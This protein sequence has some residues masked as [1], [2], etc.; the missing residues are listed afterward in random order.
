MIEAPDWIVLQSRS[1]MDENNLRLEA[2]AVNK[3]MLHQRFIHTFDEMNKESIMVSRSKVHRSLY[4]S[5]LHTEIERSGC[6]RVWQAWLNYHFGAR[7]S[8]RTVRSGHKSNVA[9]FLRGPSL[10]R[11]LLLP[12][13]FFLFILYCSSD[14]HQSST[15]DRTT[16]IEPILSTTRT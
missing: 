5:H 9:L 4:L 7:Y 10:K 12:S 1:S 6:V 16:F 11:R 3:K 8:K 15:E 2:A 14:C 13:S